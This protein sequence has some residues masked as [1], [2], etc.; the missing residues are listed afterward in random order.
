MRTRQRVGE[1]CKELLLD[2]QGMWL[3]GEAD[4]SISSCLFLA[5]R[6][7][8]FEAYASLFSAGWKNIRLFVCEAAEKSRPYLA[9]WR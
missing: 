7:N 9:Y 3:V 1:R 8:L 4:L 5:C 2:L 6:A